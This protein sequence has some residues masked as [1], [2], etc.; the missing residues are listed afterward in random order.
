MSRLPTPGG[1]N[2]TWGEVLNDFLAVEHNADG[3]LKLRTDPAL[4][5]KYTKPSGGIPKSDLAAAVQTSLDTADARDATKLQGTSVDGSAPSDGQVLVYSNSASA[6]LPGTASSTTVNDATTGSKGIVQLA[7]DLAG[8]A[9]APTVPELANKEPI[10][11]AG[12][13][14]QYW[15]GDKSWQTLNKTAV[16]LSNV[17]NT[18]DASK[19]ISTATQTALDAKAA[20]SAVVHNTGTET[21]GGVKTFTGNV[22]VQNTAPALYLTESDQ[23]AP[24]GAYR[25]DASGDALR[26]IRSSTVLAQ[27]DNNTFTF[28]KPVAGTTAAFTSGTLSAPTT[29]SDSIATYGQI[30][31]KQDKATVI[32]G[33]AEYPTDGVADN[34]Q[35]QAAL[36]AVHTAGGGVVEY[37]KPLYVDAMIT[38]YKDVTLVGH[39]DLTPIYPSASFSAGVVLRENSGAA[40]GLTLIDVTVDCSLKSQ[41]GGIHIYQGNYVTLIRPHLKN[42][43][44]ADPTSK[45]GIRVGNYT[46]GS[47]DG[48]A[49]HGMLILE[50]KIINCDT[51]TFE[52]MLIVNQQDYRI[53]SPY[54]EGNTNS[55]AYQLMLYVNNKHA[56][57]EAPHFEN[58]NANSIG[59]MES[60]GVVVTDITDDHSADYTLCTII[61]TRNVLVDTVNAKNTAVSPTSAAFNFFDRVNGPDGFTQ[62]V[63]D[64]ENVSISNVKLDGWKTTAF[65]QLGAPSYT[66]NQKDIQFHNFTVKNQA[67]PFNIGID[68]ASNNLHDWDFNNIRIL[69]WTGTTTGAWQLRGYSSGVGQ[70]YGFRFRNC[71][72][73]ASSGVGSFAAIRNI[74]ATV[75][76]V[77]NTDF[78]GTFTGYGA[79]SIVSGGVFQKVSNVKGVNPDTLYAQGNVTGATTF[80]RVNGK[81]ITAT[82]TGNA[83]A[84]LTS[85]FQVGDE[86]TL[87][88][89]QD[90]TGSRTMTWPSNAKFGH[91]GVYVLTTAASSVDTVTF[92]WDGTNWREKNRAPSRVASVPEGGTGVAT[93]T[94]MV[95]A[96][97]TSAFTAAVSGTDY[98]APSALLSRKGAAPAALTDAA[99]IATDA[100]LS[101]NFRVTLGG[102]RTLGN[103]TNAVDGQPLIWEITQ[104]GAG[105]RLLSLDTKFAFG[106]DVTGITLSTTAGK[107]DFLVAIYNSTADKFRVVDFVKGY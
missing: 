65:C 107:T 97:G 73:V 68:D 4:T 96:N 66:L 32:V 79:L 35:L 71:K 102:D 36:D 84:T 44:T 43:V 95:K 13:S 69:S 28:N 52:Q 14:A 77:E 105:N 6:W 75:E 49:S 2:N 9:S 17:D 24:A 45:W 98:M 20:D 8:T 51:G 7:G 46:N 78:S 103:P 74:G 58:C 23:T 55:L 10:I 21:I 59:M 48:T 56:V 88:L 62:I 86:L 19:P 61:N 22:T 40:D 31:G 85:G 83:T 100:S 34:V 30:S 53:L 38:L 12:T 70:M 91:G 99:T 57:I 94:G 80:T 41:V 82:L 67:V 60:D 29:N 16:G 25:I 87:I 104:D 37:V 33:A 26:F 64:T 11:T 81:I 63:D 42:M 101:C 3:S 90:G 72:C 27:A 54:F 89:T 50:P 15:R 39:G 106:T 93:L 5:G 1:D 76:T 47:P 18:S 92:T